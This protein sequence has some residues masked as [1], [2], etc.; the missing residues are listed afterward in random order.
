MNQMKNDDSIEQYRPTCSSGESLCCRPN[1]PK[2]RIPKTTT[3]KR[4]RRTTTS[5]RRPRRTTTTTT[6]TTTS[7][8]TT[9]DFG[10]T[11]DPNECEQCP[12]LFFIFIYLFTKKVCLNFI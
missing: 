1:F 9:T 3:T 2:C 8:T 6:T 5:T 10:Q 11:L 12:S 4:R 7:T